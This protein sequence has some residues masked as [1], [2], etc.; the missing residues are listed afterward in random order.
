MLR[1]IKIM[2]KSIKYLFFENP[3]FLNNNLGYKT[4]MYLLTI[5]LMKSTGAYLIDMK[6]L[7]SIGYARRSSII[8]S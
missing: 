2:P 8:S 5:Y 3:L 4:D 6:S 7:K 1:L